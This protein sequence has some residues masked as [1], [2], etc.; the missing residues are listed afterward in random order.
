MATSTLSTS[1]VSAAPPAA[2]L[3]LDLEN[4]AG[5]IDR[6]DFRSKLERNALLLL[7]ALKLPRDFAVDTRQDMIEKFDDRHLRAEP[8]PHRAEL[9]T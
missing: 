9:H 1:S 6:R 8:P 5:A 7:Q 2:G 3:D 4:F